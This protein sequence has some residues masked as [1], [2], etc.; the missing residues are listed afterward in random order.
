MTAG[1]SPTGEEY[2]AAMLRRRADRRARQAFVDLAIHLAPPGGVILDFGAGPGIDAKLYAARGYRVCGYDVDP[3]MRDAFQRCCRDEILA[4][5]VNIWPADYAE[6]LTST[7]LPVTGAADLV[8]ANFA[9]MNLVDSPRDLFR[10]FHALTVPQGRVLVSVLNPFYVGD[11]RY[12]WWWTNLAALGRQGEFGL[13]IQPFT[14]YRRT[15]RFLAAAA[16]PYFRLDRIERGLPK[17]GTFRFVPLGP[18]ARFSCRYLFLVFSKLDVAATE[19]NPPLP[20]EG[21]AH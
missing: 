3:Q 14:V 19:E 8:A 2:A 21:V 5:Q 12:P 9:P 4:G 18:F 7:A 20:R 16:S 15:S 6:F 17:A 10:A 11:L 1:A 13:D